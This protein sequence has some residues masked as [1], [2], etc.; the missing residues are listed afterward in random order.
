MLESK[1]LGLLSNVF[2][3]PYTN[4]LPDYSVLYIGT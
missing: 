1:S 3:C 2:F 4:E